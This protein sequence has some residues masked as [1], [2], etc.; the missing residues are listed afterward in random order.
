VRYYIDISAAG[1]LIVTERESRILAEFLDEA[2]VGGARVLS[3][4]LLETELRRLASRL[5]LPQTSVSGL[6][7]RFDLLLP[8]LA[9]F[10]EAGMLAGRHL[11]SLDALHLAAALRAGVDRLITYDDRQAAAAETFGLRVIRPS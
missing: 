7:D 10:R 1:K 2:T 9:W 6:L 3:S 11:R 5:E 4:V 8:D